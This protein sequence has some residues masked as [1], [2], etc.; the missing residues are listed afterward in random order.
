MPRTFAMWRG[1]QYD[2]EDGEETCMSVQPPKDMM[3]YLVGSTRNAIQPAFSCFSVGM[4]TSSLQ[5]PHAT[6]PQL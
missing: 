4:H 5:D 1:E 2:F 6:M 3:R